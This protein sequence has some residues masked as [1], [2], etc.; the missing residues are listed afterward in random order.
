MYRC[1]E[2]PTLLPAADIPPSGSFMVTHGGGAA[3][4]S[5]RVAG[6]GRTAP[7]YT[8]GGATAV[9]YNLHGIVTGRAPIELKWCDFTLQI[10]SVGGS[11][12][13]GQLTTNVCTNKRRRADAPLA[14][15]APLAPQ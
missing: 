12:R 2:P 3:V 8:S 9:G 14:P 15:L 7:Q 11:H 10:Y 4:G 1:L 5:A 13:R 6:S